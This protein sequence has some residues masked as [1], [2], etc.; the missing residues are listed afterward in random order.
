MEQIQMLVGKTADT[1]FLTEV[2]ELAES[3]PNMLLDK[4][5][6]YHFGPKFL[7]ELEMVMPESTILRDSHDAGIQLQHLIESLPEVERCFVHIDYSKREVDDHDPEAPLF[8]KTYNGSPSFT[9]RLVDKIAK[10]EEDP[11]RRMQT[12][13]IEKMI[14]KV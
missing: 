10:I 11:E 2:K 14:K 1:D 8:L 12:E 7:V 3:Q 13:A 5:T 6:A 9:E 4:V